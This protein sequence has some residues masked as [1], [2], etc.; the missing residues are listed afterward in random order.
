MLSLDETRKVVVVDNFYLGNT[1][2][3]INHSQDPRLKIVRA[4]A[5][6]FSTMSQICEEFKPQVY[7]NFAVVPLPTSLTYPNW[8]VKINIELALVACEL[9]RL[10]K[11]QRYLHISSSEVYGTARFVP[12][13]E[14]HPIDSETPYAAAKASADQVILSYMKTFG[15]EALI[16]RPFNNYGPRQN[17]LEYAGV[18]PI[19]IKKM[20]KSEDCVIFGNG[21]QTRDFIYVEETAQYILACMQL[22]HCWNKGPIN[23][24]S[25]LETSILDIFYRLQEILKSKSQLIF[26]PSRPGDVLRHCGDSSLLVEL[27]ALSVPKKLSIK[28]LENTIAFYS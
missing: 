1:E 22:E 8:S 19:F 24:C 15:I 6:D 14:S 28:G 26:A 21:L 10:G 5:S 7:I 12:M 23:I 25:G 18:I 3:L 2:N 27:T 9:A 11:I 20:L 4:D 17:S 13:N 16:L